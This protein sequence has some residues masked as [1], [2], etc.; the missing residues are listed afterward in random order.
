[1]LYRAVLLL[2]VLKGV[3][4]GGASADRHLMF[5]REV[6]D[7]TEE[8]ATGV[9][10]N[11]CGKGITP[12]FI[13]KCVY[14]DCFVNSAS[15]AHPPHAGLSRRRLGG[16]TGPF[17]DGADCQVAPTAT[18]GCAAGAATCPAWTDVPTG[19]TYTYCSGGDS[20]ASE[21][22]LGKTVGTNVCSYTV[23]NPSNA[24]QS[25]LCKTVRCQVIVRE[26]TTTDAAGANQP[27]K[28]RGCNFIVRV[29]DTHAVPSV[30]KWIMWVIFF[31]AIVVAG[32]TSGFFIMLY[33]TDVHEEKG[34]GEGSNE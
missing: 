27:V 25:C 5:R 2:T 10:P 19:S 33:G 9:E 23:P 26:D 20:R 16:Y 31:M 22:I 12:D 32:I 15:G 3:F 21:P 13:K 8:A 14:T 1:M 24:Q 6:H 29:E 30:P 28:Y 4:G 17:P 11:L 7:D 34:E 18:N